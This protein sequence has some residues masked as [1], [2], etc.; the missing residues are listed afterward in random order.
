[1]TVQDCFIAAQGL[2]ATNLSEDSSLQQYAVSWVNLALHE[3][4]DVENSIRAFIK[5]P[6]RPVL[7]DVPQLTELTD[8]IPY[9]PEI[10]EH[11]LVYRLAAQMSKDDDDVFH[12][13]YYENMFLLTLSRCQKLKGEPGVDVYREGEQ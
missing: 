8:E 13:Q 3:A 7:E 5:D 10:S 1:M 12:E 4:F 9:S 11:C 6:E 2:L